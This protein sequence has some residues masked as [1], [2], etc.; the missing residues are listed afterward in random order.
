MWDCETAEVTLSNV[1]DSLLFFMK[2][3]NDFMMNECMMR[4]AEALLGYQDADSGA[5][6]VSL[7]LSVCMCFKIEML[8]YLGSRVAGQSN[9]AASLLY[10]AGSGCQ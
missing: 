8:A 10:E 9:A 6:D 4:P 2:P 1:S 7:C 3:F 5:L